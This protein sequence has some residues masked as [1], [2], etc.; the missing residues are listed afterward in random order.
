MKAFSIQSAS[1]LAFLLAVCVLTSGCNSFFAETNQMPLPIP[2]PAPMPAPEE[3][4]HEMSKVSHPTYTIESPDVLLISAS[5]VVPKMPY[6]IETLD[7]LAVQVLGTGDGPPIFGN[8]IVDGDGN[9]DLG[10]GYGRVHLNELTIDEARTA[11]MTYLITNSL[12]AEPQVS[13][14]LSQSPGFQQIAGQHQVGPDGTVNLGVYG[15]VRLSGLTVKEAADAI[16]VKLSEK[17]E[18]PEATVDVAT[19]SSKKYYII[20]E[21]AGQGDNVIPVAITGNETVLDA[22]A[23]IG[24]LSQISSQKIWI[25][26]PS[27]DD[28]GGHQILPVDWAAITAG[29]QSATNYQIM[30]GD[31][32]FIAQDTM[33]TVNTM[34]QK[35]IAPIERVFGFTSVSVGVLNRIARFGLRR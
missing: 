8:F 26:R 20:T 14:I 6:T 24:G 25:A 32:V 28:R 22:I 4:P 27:A 18:A 17:L 7:V 35:I 12:V 29:A 9:L 3:P 34:V 1:L 33:V 11:I 10:A 13:V 16:N 5:K 21:G 23:L 30:P 2:E 15:R 31:R 19:F